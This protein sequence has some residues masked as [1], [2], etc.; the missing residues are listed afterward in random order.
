[1]PTALESLLDPIGRDRFREQ[2]YGK[3]PL[4]I[5]GHAQKLAGLFT[6]D[7]LNRLLNASPWPH[8]NVQVSPIY[9]DVDSPS[10]I[11][12]QCR[13]GSSLIFNQ[14]HLYDPKIGEFVRALEAET[15]EPANAVMFLSQPS[16]AAYPIHFDRHDV[17]VLHVH[18]R[19]AWSVY[20]RTVERPVHD[21]M[22]E[23]HDPPSQ[24]SLQCELTPGDVLYIPRGTGT[25][26][27]PSRDC[28]FT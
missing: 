6:W 25:A 15:G 4:L 8:P 21:W 19:K 26:R 2:H 3:E 7:D 27:S 5:R 11:I 14:I 1:M 22:D 17:F 28:P 10:S 9:T 23:P 12:E 18:G 20:D 16:Q 13:K 24:P